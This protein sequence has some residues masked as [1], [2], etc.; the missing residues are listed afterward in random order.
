MAWKL[1]E[2]Y[3]Y[4]YRISDEGM[5]EV[6]KGKWLPVKPRISWNRA[7]VRLR[8]KDGKQTK[9]PVV[10]LMAEKF[11]GGIKPG[12]CVRHKDRA[13]LGNALHNL[14][15]VPL[16][17][18]GELGNQASRKPI[19]KIDRDGN[20]VEIY[21]SVQEAAD[22]NYISPMAVTRR[23]KGQIKYPFDLIGYSFK[24]DR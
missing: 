2:G 21:K 24:F 10:R 16:N 20:E 22:A 12:H 14:E 17:K 11:M 5:V 13:R 19:I 23:C 15:Q 8:T 9:V 18:C 4:P 7:H 1:I 6:Y 3:K